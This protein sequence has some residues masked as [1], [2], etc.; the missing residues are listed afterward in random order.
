MDRNNQLEV[1]PGEEP[2]SLLG[3]PSWKPF[4][5]GKA[6]IGDDG[7]EYNS[8]GALEA[9]NMLYRRLHFEEIKP[10]EPIVNGIDATILQKI[11]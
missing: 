5:D 3:E 10:K 2:V 4:S 11:K 7:R 1:L 6:R 9:G 8:P